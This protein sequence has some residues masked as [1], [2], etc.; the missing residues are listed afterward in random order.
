METFKKHVVDK[1][2][3]YYNIDGLNNSRH[4]SAIVSYNDSSCKIFL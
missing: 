3:N 2:N 4:F 1:Y